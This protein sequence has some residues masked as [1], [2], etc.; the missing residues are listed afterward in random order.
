MK[1]TGNYDYFEYFRRCGG[2]ACRA[3]ELLSRSL[4]G[5]EP[6][7]LR[8][9]LDEMHRLEHE[10]DEAKHEMIR[11]LAH[12]FITPIEREDIVALAQEL[13][14][15]IDAADDI[16]QR[17]YL[18]N[19]SSVR[20]EATTFAELFLKSCKALASALEQLSAFKKKGAEISRALI[21]VASFESAG[22][23]LHNES[24]RRLFTEDVGTRELL[25]WN[26]MFEGFESCL[27]AC[28]HAANAVETVIM[29]NS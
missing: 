3:A 11:L 21:E 28:E 29:K 17:A 20:S 25:I 24:L 9:R 12:E 27:D 4:Q 22:D 2:Y 19:I 26:S 7:S 15:V 13:D 8:D 14:N 16:L 10:A 1:R 18:F 6:A 23:T 5:F